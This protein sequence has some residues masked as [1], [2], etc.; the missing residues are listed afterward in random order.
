MEYKKSKLKDLCDIR[1]GSSPRPIDEYYTDNGVPWVK[2]SDATA[3]RKYIL[4]TSTFI[5]ELGVKGSVE[6]LVGDL[7]LSNSGTPALPKI[8]GIN[9]CIHDG[10]LLLRNFIDIDK[11]YLYYYLLGF[12]K[13]IE[14][15]STG[16]I[17]QNLNTDRIKN[18][19]ISYPSL[20]TQKEIS[21]S[22]SAI[23]NAIE[24]NT[25]IKFLIEEYSQLLFHKWFVDFN[26]PNENGEPYK[27][28][29]GEMVEVDG[30]MIPKNWDVKKLK[31]CI[32][33]IKTGLNPRDNFKL[34]NGNIKY[35]TVKNLT[36]DGLI[37]FSNCD[38]IDSEA[39][40]II[41]RRSQINI[42]DILFASISPLGRCSII[43]EKAN[44][45]EINESVFSIRPNTDVVS[46]EYL[47]RFLMSGQFIKKAEQSSVGSVFNGIRIGTLENMDIVVPCTRSRTEFQ[48]IISPLLR[49]KYLLNNE[50]SS[51]QKYRDLLI[52]KL[53]K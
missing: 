20:E 49:K 14:L 22:L 24:N 9:A 10:W 17:F 23:D 7:I 34:G 6:V 44:D 28:S 40:E 35:V 26:F 25:Q 2:I 36:L 43:Y 19:V 46:T 39:K 38:L 45:W 41:N 12:R 51:L 16:T 18:L 31:N 15:L 11:D 48:K 30:K 5:K 13:K 52:N 32:Q 47:F 37:D 27:D 50:N 29:G 4:E 33:H 8:M 1:R 42:G 21:F 53:I 3:S